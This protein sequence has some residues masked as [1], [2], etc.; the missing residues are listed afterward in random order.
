MAWTVIFFLNKSLRQRGRPVMDRCSKPPHW[1]L[2]PHYTS[3]LTLPDADQLLTVITRWWVMVQ[4]SREVALARVVGQRDAG[5]VTDPADW[6]IDRWST[7]HSVILIALCSPS[8]TTPAIVGVGGQEWGC[9]VKNSE[10]ILEP[11]YE[12]WH[13]LLFSLV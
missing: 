7:L 11:L 1:L 13:G 5:G 10:T 4:F 12:I 6:P 3:P 8:I 9:S 2:V